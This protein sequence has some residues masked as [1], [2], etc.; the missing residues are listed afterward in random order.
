M[1]IAASMVLPL[2]SIG[3]V[4]MPRPLSS[5]ETEL[6]GWITISIA[7]QWPPRASSIELSTTSK[8]IL[9]RPEPSLVSPMYMPGRLR[10]AS[11]P[12]STEMESALYSSTEACVLSASDMEMAA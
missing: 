7:L 9:C 5:T 3:P 1:T 2:T 8:T 10:T 4:G 12:S 6:S 11:R